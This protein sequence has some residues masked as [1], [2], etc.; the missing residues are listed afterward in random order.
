VKVKEIIVTLENKMQR[1]GLVQADNNITF[2]SSQ[3]SVRYSYISERNKL[4]VSH[5]QFRTGQLAKNKF[6]E[7]NIHLWLNKWDMLSYPENII[8]YQMSLYS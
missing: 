6:S 8:A 7:Y 4:D 3:K 1:L 2:Y 5:S